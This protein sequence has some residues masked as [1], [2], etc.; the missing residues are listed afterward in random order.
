MKEQNIIMQ[1]L[2]KDLEKVSFEDA[3]RVEKDAKPIF[4][5]TVLKIRGDVKKDRGR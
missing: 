1:T 5:A 2:D 3:K 4:R